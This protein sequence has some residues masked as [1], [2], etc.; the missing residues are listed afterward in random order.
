MI[1][2][3]LLYQCGFLV[4]R[5]VKSGM[6]FV[7][8][9]SRFQP[10]SALAD[11]V[12]AQ[13]TRRDALLAEREATL[14]AQEAE[15]KRR[16]LKIQQLTLELA[17]HK[18]VRFGKKSEALTR[19]QLALFDEVGD[20]D[21]AAIVAEIEQQ[22]PATPRQP[23]RSGRKPLP[24]ELPRIE[25]RHDPESCACGRCGREQ[26][27]IGEDISEQLDVEPARFFVH[28]H[29]RSQWACRDCETVTAAPVP[30][31]IIDGGLAAPGLHAWVLIQKYLDHLPLY[32]IERISERHGVAIARSTLAQWVGQLGVHLQPL[33]DRLAERLRQGAVLHADETPVQ[34]LD[35]GRGKTK[36]AY[37]WAYRSNDL[38]AGPPIVVFDYQT[39]RSGEHARHFLRT[40]RGHLM[41]D[42]YSGYK[43]LFQDGVTELGCLAHVRRKFFD[44]Q[45]TGPHPVAEEALR[46]IGELYAVEAEADEHGQDL[47][48]RLALRRHAAL[49][50]LQALRDWWIA[51]RLKTADGSGLA[52]ALDHGLKRWPAL[53]RYAEWGHLP[54]DNNPVENAIRP[55]ALGRR[56]WLFTGSERA[57]RRA[58]AIQSLLATAK[59]NG[60]EPYAW[61]KDTLEKLPTWPYSRIDELLPLRATTSE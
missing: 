54:I 51:Q 3:N 13:L 19:E 57:G 48:A 16:E 10:D 12:A 40:W 35:P 20:E 17:M 9:L 39:S 56:N 11:W 41:V 61:L 29:I 1:Q 8:E 5:V 6:H 44:L 52:R 47:V 7:A 2:R 27:K 26:V 55:I 50:K 21:G 46:R 45:A 14:A 42:D 4:C 60:I 31:A 33:A 30:A 38:E 32:R 59:L 24:A 49:P 34:Q 36:R 28:R 37:L 18:R 22:A 25:H 53:Q 58:A 15:L 43:A 23:R